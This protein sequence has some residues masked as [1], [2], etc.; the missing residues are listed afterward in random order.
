MSILTEKMKQQLADLRQRFEKGE[1]TGDE[2]STLM[3]QA[4]ETETEKPSEDINDAWLTACSELMAYVDR[5]KLAQLPDCSEQIRSEL[6]ATIRKEQKT[7]KKRIVYH[8]TV[9][10]ACLLLVFVGFSYSRQWFRATLTPDE[11]VY[12]LSGQQVEISTTNQ[13]A[14]DSDEAWRECETTNFQELCDFLGAT[15]QVPTWV[16]EGWKLNGYYASTDSGSRSITVVYEKADEKYCLMYDY[17]QAEDISTISVDFY[18]D[19]TGKNVRLDNGMDIYLT[20]NTGDPVAVWTTAS[21]YACATGP[22]TVDDLKTFIL[23]IK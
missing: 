21:T 16:P 22:I 9:A 2:L 13:A 11:Q 12:T 1:L 6:V 15:P 7:Q 23:G 18:Q 19:G 3:L 17:T 20:T 14:A 8:A 10:A 5:D 4:I